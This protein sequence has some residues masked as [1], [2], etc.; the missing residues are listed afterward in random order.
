[1]KQTLLWQADDLKQNLE[2][3]AHLLHDCVVGGA[4]IGFI[5]P[6]PI[7]EARTFW[8]HKIL[9]DLADNSR[10]LFVTLTEGKPIGTVSVILAT[11]ANQPHRGEISK[12]MVHPNARRQ[13]VA[14]KLMIAAEI[15]AAN[16]GKTLLTLDTRSG[17]SAEPLY[18]A[19]GF[20]TAGMIPNYCMDVTGQRFDSTTY[21]FKHLNGPL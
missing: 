16:Q 12:L 20:E 13:G 17:D 21:M 4:S 6:H 18:H 5:L 8:R 7:D 3:M 15:Y 1:M 2:A 10:A 11:P 19:L 9:P 14:R